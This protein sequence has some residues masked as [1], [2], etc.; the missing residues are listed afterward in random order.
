MSRISYKLVGET[1][2]NAI[3]KEMSYFS[4]V[5]DILESTKTLTYVSSYVD[6]LSSQTLISVSTHWEIFVSDI[7]VAYI[8]RNPENFI[9]YMENELEKNLNQNWKDVR[10]KFAPLK[11][12]NPL[13]R[14]DIL[15]IMN[16]QGGNMRF[17]TGKA[18]KEKASVLISD[19]YRLGI[20]KLTEDDLAII[21]L[22]NALRNRVVHNSARSRSALKGIASNKI[23][24]KYGLYRSQKQKFGPGVYL[25]SEFRTGSGVR[26]IEEF[27]EHIKRIG[28]TIIVE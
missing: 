11:I 22:L 7:F 2:A 3:S 26:R 1:F 14:Q 13:R 4:K 23:L 9:L 12:P 20:E 19:D 8:N 25:R 5:A 10:D 28:E 16:T 21:D 24:E 6:K 15:D 17:R 27:V 18:I